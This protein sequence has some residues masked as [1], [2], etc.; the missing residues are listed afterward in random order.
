MDLLG[1]PQSG[2]LLPSE[3]GA[4]GCRFYLNYIRVRR[5]GGRAAV[6]SGEFYARA[7]KMGQVAGTLFGG[8]GFVVKTEMDLS[9]CPF[10][11]ALQIETR[12]YRRRCVQSSTYIIGRVKFDGR[13]GERKF[14]YIANT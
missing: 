11:A 2:K 7:G 1:G 6:I 14:I 9:G 3:V 13:A 12:E 4:R 8:C 10:D 5:M